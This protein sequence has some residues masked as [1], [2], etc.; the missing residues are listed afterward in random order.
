MYNCY[1]VYWDDSL[2]A[3]FHYEYQAKRDIDAMLER[4]QHVS[5]ENFRIEPA[6]I[7]NIGF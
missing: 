5:I 3:I 6:F 1:R 7:E 4:Y 2:Y